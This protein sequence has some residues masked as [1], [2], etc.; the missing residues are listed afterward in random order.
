LGAFYDRND[1]YVGFS[2]S[3]LNQPRVLTVD[4]GDKTFTVKRTFYLNGG[5][6][7]QTADERFEVDPMALLM[8]TAFVKP[9]LNIGVNV[10][11]KKRYWGGL[12]YRIG[13]ALGVLGGITVNEA[14]RLGISYEYPLSKLIATNSGNLEI[15]VSYSFELKFTKRVKKYK[16]IRF[17]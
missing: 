16:S 10:F 7:W 5:Y 9:Q 14:F 12:S 15:F 3:H 6:R 4:S 13:D 11:Y 8:F 2:C 1:F 17:L